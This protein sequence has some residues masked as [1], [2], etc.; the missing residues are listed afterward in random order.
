MAQQSL[1]VSASPIGTLV[2]LSTNLSVTYLF[3]EAISKG[4]TPTSPPLLPTSS[5]SL[6]S[7][8]PTFDPSNPYLSVANATVVPF[9]SFLLHLSDALSFLALSISARTEF[10]AFWLPHFNKIHA[11]GEDIAF[12]FLNQAEHE[13]NATLD[14]T[15]TP[16]VITRVFLLFKRVGKDQ[17]Q[18]ARMRSVRPQDWCGIVGVERERAS[19]K[20]LFRVLEWGG[21]EVTC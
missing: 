7:T 12:R 20:D 5:N 4:W 18:E 2:D 17:W 13:P 9:Q 3:W 8:K 6:L 11:R 10:I 19:D 15:P 16:D 21:M 1:G 14:V